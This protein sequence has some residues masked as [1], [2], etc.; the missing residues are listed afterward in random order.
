MYMMSQHE[1][2]AT[3]RERARLVALL[4]REG[5]RDE[6]VLAAMARVPRH[7][8]LPSAARYRAYEDRAQSIG[9]GQT[10]SQ[11]WI[12]ARMTELAEVGPDSKVLDVGT[13]SGYQAAVLAELGAQVYGI[14]LLAELA[15]QASER[16]DLLGYD[17]VDVVRGDGYGGRPDRAPYDAIIVAA[18]PK[19]VPSSLIKQLKPGG[20]LVIPVGPE[21][22]IQ[23]LQLVVKTEQGEVEV[24]DQLP[25]RFVPLVRGN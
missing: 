2:D 4:R 11:P 3:R 5:I 18:A 10:I 19:E 16:L 22:G 25:V 20:R 17:N 9:W 15:E 13:G 7:T 24:S 1:S 23:S 6:R 12:V 8:F 21:R 14:E